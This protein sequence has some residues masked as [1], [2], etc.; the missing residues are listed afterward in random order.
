[1]IP[2]KCFSNVPQPHRSKVLQGREGK[3]TPE[4]SARVSSQPAIPG[5]DSFF[6]DFRCCFYGF[7][8]FLSL[9]PVSL[10][11]AA[12]AGC[13]FCRDGLGREA[14]SCWLGKVGSPSV[15]PG[16]FWG[17]IPW[18]S[19]GWGNLGMNPGLLSR[20]REFWERG[21]QRD[22]GQGIPGVL[23]NSA[24]SGTRNSWSSGECSGIMDREFLEFCVF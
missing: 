17:G 10:S 23:G 22:Q 24:G 8:I 5:V 15:T 6:R 14:L 4:V 18:L 1:M 2:Q 13:G 16:M 11:S 12:A 9:F 3:T 7:F 21:M 20:L 19:V